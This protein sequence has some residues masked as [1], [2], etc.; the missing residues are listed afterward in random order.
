MVAAKKGSWQ[1]HDAPVEAPALQKYLALCKNWLLESDECRP[2]AA[3]AAVVPPAASSDGSSIPQQPCAN[4]ALRASAVHP[5]NTFA[6]AMCGA[7]ATGAT[8][9]VVCV[10]PFTW[11]S[12]MLLCASCNLHEQRADEQ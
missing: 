8:G 1:E 3:A 11:T 4:L 9:Q 12:S 5:A 2:D 6:C 10:N 7:E